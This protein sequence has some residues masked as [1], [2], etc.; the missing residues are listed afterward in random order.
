MNKY[1]FLDFDGV[2]NSENWTKSP[3]LTLIGGCFGVDPNAVMFIN[4]IVER[5]QCQ[6]VF[7]STWRIHHST[8]E[9]RQIL[10]DHGFKYPESV[11]DSTGR[12]WTLMDREKDRTAFLAEQ[13]E[14]YGNWYRGY[15]IDCWLNDNV[16]GRKKFA[17]L[18]DD[19]D[20][21]KHKNRHVK[22]TWT[23]G[24]SQAHVD[25]VC[26]VLSFV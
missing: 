17:I 21:W 19:S 15:E 26:E 12:A 3:A 4:Q 5:T 7:S 22:T 8:E 2:L 10:V 13:N 14:K 24:I 20:M 25:K 11:I 9:L 18:D 16:K 1:L 6:I 23:R